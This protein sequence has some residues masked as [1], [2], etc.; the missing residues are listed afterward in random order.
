QATAT[1]LAGVSY[2]AKEAIESSGAQLPPHL[3]LGL[4]YCQNDDQAEVQT[5]APRKGQPRKMA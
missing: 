2:Q 3:L 4:E 5:P 1:D